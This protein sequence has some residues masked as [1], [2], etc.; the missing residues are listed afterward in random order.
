MFWEMLRFAAPIGTAKRNTAAKRKRML[1]FARPRLGFG[2]F[3]YA[4]KNNYYVLR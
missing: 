3:V 2:S 1:R 4:V